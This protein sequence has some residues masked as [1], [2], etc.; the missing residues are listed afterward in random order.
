MP[1][2]RRIG[3][4]SYR[5]QCSVWVWGKADYLPLDRGPTQTQHLLKDELLRRT[6]VTQDRALSIGREG[7]HV[8]IPVLGPWYPQNT[9]GPLLELLP[10]LP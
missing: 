7:V 3:S 8:P 9:V 1:R 6:E 2:A 10:L 4:D 5:S